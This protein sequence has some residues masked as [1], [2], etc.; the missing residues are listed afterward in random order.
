[1]SK[2]LSA[3]DAHD[4]LTLGGLPSRAS[5]GPEPAKRFDLLILRAQ[6]ALLDGDTAGVGRIRETVNGIMEPSRIFESP[7][8][9]DFQ[10]VDTLFAETEVEGIV[11]SLRVIRANAE[12]EQ[13][14][15]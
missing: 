5:V 13:K 10:P 15:A 7:Y 9:D 4:A 1:M 11:T 6:V 8:T 14:R 3:E 12:P 2:G